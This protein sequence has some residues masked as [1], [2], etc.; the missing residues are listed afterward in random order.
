MKHFPSLLAIAALLFS[1]LPAGAQHVRTSPVPD[2]YPFIEPLPRH[3]TVTAEGQAVAL[4]NDSSFWGGTIDFGSF[5]MADGHEVSVT[6]SLDEDIHTLELLPRPKDCQVKQKGK[7]LIEITTRKAGWQQ[8]LVV[9]GT[10]REG[11]VLH[12]FCNRYDEGVLPAG[13]RYDETS[14]THLFGPGYYDLQQLTGSATLTVSGQQKIYLAPGAVVNGRLA[15]VNGNGA[16]IYGN[17]MVCNNKTSLVTVDHST[18]CTVEDITV[19]GHAWHAWQVIMNN[20]RN[21]RMKGMKILNPHY[22][23]VDGI[24]VVNSSHCAVDSCFIR[25]NDDAIAVKGLGNHKPEESAAMSHLRFSRLQ[26]WNDCNNA[27]G[28]GAETHCRE[29]SHISV[30]DCD[31]LFSYDDPVHH[32]NLNERAAINICSLHGTFFH[33]LLFENIRVYH[34]QRLIGMGFRQ[35]FW[36]GQLEGDQ[37]GDGGISDVTFRNILSE[38]KGNGPLNNKILLYEWHRTGTPDKLLRNIVFDNVRINGKRV[39]NARSALFDLEPAPG[40]DLRKELTF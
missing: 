35:N 21:V 37:T 40:H 29:Y 7:R 16:K 15:I 1:L 6:V 3:F 8:T 34:C 11:H 32:N 13:Y 27:F 28:I 22:A 20:C 12:L 31:I 10:P 24:D 33:D 9:N 30:T 36:F 18:Q 39:R 19:H 5:E 38:E 17:G 14:G 2:G 25:A 23:S 26:L 4:Y